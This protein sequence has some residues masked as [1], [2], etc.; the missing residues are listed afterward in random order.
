ML[1]PR[2]VLAA[3]LA[4]VLGTALPADARPAAAETSWKTAES[5]LAQGLPDAAL[6]QLRDALKTA[7]S[8]IE[9]HNA[10]IDLMLEEQFAAEV[11]A[12]YRE[13]KAANPSA[14]NHYLHGRA[15]A[16]SGD[17]DGARSD[18]KAALG[19]D[20]THVWSLEGLASLALIEGRAKDA[21]DL[22]ESARAVAPQRSAIHN[23]IAATKVRMGDIEG[24]FAA[25]KAATEADPSDHHAWLNW[26]AMLSRQGD[27]SAAAEKLRQAVAVAPGYPLAHVNLAYVYCRLKKWD[28]AAAHF[29]T[30][31]AINPRDPNAAA[32][33]DLVNGIASGRWPAT[34]FPPMADALEAEVV[35]PNSA[36]QKWREVIALA[37]DFGPAHGHVGMNLAKKGDAQGALAALEEAARVAPDDANARYNLGYLLLG[38][39][40]V[41]DALPHLEAA[42][43]LSPRDP[44]AMTGIALVHLAKGDPDTS[45]A[46]Y[47]KALLANPLDATLWVQKG[48]TLAALGEFD[49]GAA[50]VRQALSLAPRFAAARAQLVTILRE[51]RRFDEALAELD[52]LAK[53]LPDNPSIAVERAN[54]QAARRGAGATGK[55]IHLRQIVVKDQ[56]TAETALAEL[57]RGE[58]F[59]KVARSRGLGPE[60]SRGGDVGWVDPSEMRPEVASV[61]QSL[62]AGQRSGVISVNGG[63]AFL[64]VERVE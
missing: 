2:L 41:D 42:H 52:T 29:E 10:Y 54:I 18:F 16:Q 27:H 15:R 62:G 5:L 25:W 60:A 17:F 43:R 61:V 38:L 51:A 11:I 44:D 23:K 30:A 20:S 47:D 21:L 24:A 14:D 22:Y 49:D 19:K 48:T 53:M 33:R 13:R 12:E 59:A 45:L 3:C 36:L 63:K 1:D 39:E 46:W 9:I 7:P 55:G 26:G 34:A 8:D 28:D 37:P 58:T 4:L 32:S 35:D 6:A 64:I 40:R 50:A 31:L 57:A 56:A